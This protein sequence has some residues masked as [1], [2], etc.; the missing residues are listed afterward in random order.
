MSAFLHR[1]RAW[2]AYGKCCA[3]IYDLDSFSRKPTVKEEEKSVGILFLFMRNLPSLIDP[4]EKWESE[5][6][7]ATDLSAFPATCLSAYINRIIRSIFRRWVDG[8]M[9]LFPWMITLFSLNLVGKENGS[10]WAARKPKIDYRLHW[11]LR[12]RAPRRSFVHSLTHSRAR[13]KEVFFSEMNV[14]ISYRFNP[15]C[16]AGILSPTNQF[17]LFNFFNS[18]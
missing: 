15:L 9:P 8:V 3:V 6:E 7:R 5:R 18:Y 14:S 10:N 2:R 4:P 16:C 13:G 17:P 12:S 1:A 11:F